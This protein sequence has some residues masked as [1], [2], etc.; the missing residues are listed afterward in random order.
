M[1]RYAV[2]KAAPLRHA[3]HESVGR[4][5]LTTACLAAFLCCVAVIG[6]GWLA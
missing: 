5:L 2:G 1:S 6:L 3:S 4:W